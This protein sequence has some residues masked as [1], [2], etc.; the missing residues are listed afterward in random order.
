[1]SQRLRFDPF[2]ALADILGRGDLG[3]ESIQVAKGQVSQ[4]SQ[5]SR[6][7]RA[8]DMPAGLTPD[9]RDALEERAAIFEFEAK[10]PRTIA[11]RLALS[12]LKK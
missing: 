6:L 4:V 9:Q 3:E 2:A 5:V 12:E 8:I 7:S 11:E 10:L 1:M